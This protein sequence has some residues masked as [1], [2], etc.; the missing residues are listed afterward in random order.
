MEFEEVLPCSSVT[1]RRD[2]PRFWLII[3]HWFRNYRPSRPSATPGRKEP[4]TQ[5]YNEKKGMEKNVLVFLFEGSV[6]KM[7][8]GVDW[9][10]EC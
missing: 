9:G 6:E 10:E 8:S 3:L 2:C 7:M 4:V 1:Q 5:K